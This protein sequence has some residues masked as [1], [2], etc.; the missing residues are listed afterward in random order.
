MLKT[1][2]SLPS[3]FD[4]K[5]E[6]GGENPHSRYLVKRATS[7]KDYIETWNSFNLKSDLSN[8]DFKNKNVFFIGLYESGS[9]PYTLGHGKIDIEEQALNIAISGPKGNCTADASPRTF[10]IEADKNMST[11]LTKAVIV[12]GKEK[13]SL[14]IEDSF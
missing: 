9:C 4:E 8:V 13:I 11:N 1:E 14:L 2:K 10:V 7:K 12:Y 6:S 5:V 3:D